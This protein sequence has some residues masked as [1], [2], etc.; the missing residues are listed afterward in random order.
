MSNQPELYRT[1]DRHGN[2]VVGFKGYEVIIQPDGT[3]KLL[4]LG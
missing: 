4:V 2:T 3:F 1:T